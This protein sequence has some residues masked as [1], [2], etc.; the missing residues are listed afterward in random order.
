LINETERSAGV[1]FEGLQIIER[2]AMA[3]AF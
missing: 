1:P 3:I 2:L